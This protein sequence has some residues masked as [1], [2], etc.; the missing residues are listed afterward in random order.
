M[1]CCLPKRKKYRLRPCVDTT[2]LRSWIVHC[3]VGILGAFAFS[4]MNPHTGMPNKGSANILNL[5][6]GPGN[7]QIT[8]YSSLLWDISTIIPGIPVLAVVMKYNLVSGEIMSDRNSF[9]FL[10]F[11]PG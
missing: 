2:A 10:W 7:L 11:C 4:M 8:Q 1:E 5:L 3:I 6:A 9:Y